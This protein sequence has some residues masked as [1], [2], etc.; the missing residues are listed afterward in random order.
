MRL[1]STNHHLINK[2]EKTLFAILDE[3]TK[4]EVIGDLKQSQDNKFRKLEIEYSKPREWIQSF[5]SNVLVYFSAA[6]F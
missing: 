6:A 5:I 3:R 4:T 1:L 2:T